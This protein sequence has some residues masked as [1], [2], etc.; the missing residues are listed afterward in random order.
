[1][2]ILKYLIYFVIF[3]ALAYFLYYFF[4][5]NS[6]I[7]IQKGKSKKKNKD[8][9]AEILLLRDYYKIDIEKIGIIRVLKIV[10]FVNAL[11]LSILDQS[12]NN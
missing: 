10:N 2:E 6:Q 1:M 9:P 3:F 11:L 4:V 5:V 8:L 12:I 7:K